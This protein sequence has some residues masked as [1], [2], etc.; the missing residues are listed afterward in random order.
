MAASA[1]RPSPTTEL[2]RCNIKVI[3]RLLGMEVVTVRRQVCH[4][5]T[6]S[7][8]VARHY[9][10]TTGRAERGTGSRRE[11]GFNNSPKPPG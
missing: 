6:S 9:S 2:L 11:N 3:R 4:R 5:N 7:A 8:R 1:N 10:K